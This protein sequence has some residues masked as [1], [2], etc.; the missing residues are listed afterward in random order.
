MLSMQMIRDAADV[1]DG[2]ARCTPLYPAQHL[3]DNVYF[4]AENLQVTGAF[5]IRGAYY[6]VNSLTA[7]EKAKGIIACS[8]GNHAQG[9]AYSAAKSNCKSII[10]MPSSAPISKIETTKK[11]GAEVVLVD[12]VYDDTYKK[13]L[14]LKEEYGYTFVHPFNDEMVIAGQG[15]IGLELLEQCPEVD[16]VIVPVGGGGLISGI[17][18][19]IKHIKPECRVIGVQAAGAPSMFK[20][21]N[22]GH[23]I[24]L[25][26][27]STIADGIAVKTTGEITFDIVR[28]YVDDIVTVSED[29]ISSAILMLMETQK[30]VAEGA[31]AASIAA[32][33]FNKVEVNNRKTVCIVSGGNIDVSIISRVITRGLAKSGRLVEIVCKIPDTPG[34]MARMLSVIGKTRANIINIRHDR[35]SIVNT[36][37]VTTELETRDSHHIEELI[38]ALSKHGYT[39]LNKS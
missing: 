9:V 17:A 29:E 7:E 34:E 27:V 22:L 33:M 5:K 2:V 28:K 1:L 35:N 8:A 21:I 30:S 10:C 38:S 12:G 3:N 19:A 16:Q 25:D 23:I 37:F 14:Q 13:A 15:T 32:A 31:G 11:Y 39:V 4:K 20:S 6:K 24:T 26:N 36:C 18:Y